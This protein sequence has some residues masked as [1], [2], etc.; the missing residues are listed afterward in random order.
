MDSFLIASTIEQKEII[1]ANITSIP[2]IE[3]LVSFNYKIPMSYFEPLFSSKNIEMLSFL[4][5]NNIIDSFWLSSKINQACIDGFF[6]FIKFSSAIK[7]CIFT[8]QACNNAIIYGNYDIAGYLLKNRYEGVDTLTLFEE[9]YKKGDIQGIEWCKNKGIMKNSSVNID[10]FLHCLASGNKQLVTSAL[11][12]IN[13]DIQE[14]MYQILEKSIE[15]KNLE[16]FDIFIKKFHTTMEL[17]EK[18]QEWGLQHGF[19]ELLLKYFKKGPL[20]TIKNELVSEIYNKNYRKVVDW[21]ISYDINRVFTL[22]DNVAS[23][24]DLR[25]LIK[26]HKKGYKTS[27]K[28][29]EYACNNGHLLVVKY[30]TIQC[31]EGFSEKAVLNALRE[32]YFDIF[33]WLK[34]TYPSIKNNKEK[35]IDFCKE[36]NIKLPTPL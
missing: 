36:H 24:G 17:M 3:K 10:Y 30:L 31:K 29:L 26:L 23:K 11:S 4:Y 21:V 19:L 28:A 6:D 7:T 33:E 35:Y 18:I 13:F 8:K 16:I 20:F 15:G 34:D 12:N 14:Y 22:M 5:E 27:V 9:L 1:Q 2:F 25:M 32:G